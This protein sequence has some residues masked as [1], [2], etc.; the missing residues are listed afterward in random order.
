MF[1]TVLVMVLAMS[2][3]PLGDTAGKLMTGMG[4]AP[5]FVAWSRFAL[6][7]VML[8]PIGGRA[9]WSGAAYRDWRVWLRA[10]FIV[11]GI[12][13]ILTALQTEPI[14][15]VFGAF[16]VGP[17]LSYVL[18]VVLLGERVNLV[19]SALLAVGFV[20]VMLV[21]KPGFGMTPGMG[22]A[23]LAGAFYG[24]YLT[25]SRWLAG[26]VP[27]Q[28]LLMSQLLIGAVILTPFGIARIPELSLFVIGLIAL[29][30]AASMAGN[31]L[32]VW[33]YKRAEATVL[34]PLVYSQL[35]AA[36]ALGWLVFGDLPDALGWLGLAL[37][38]VSGFAALI[39]RP[40]PSN[41]RNAR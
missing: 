2:L 12:S 19:R 5:L 1:G 40:N 8:V 21:V 20:G 26:Q 30:A 9:A 37:L 3:I 16:F 34:A 7:A 38:V 18:S 11:G 32:L 27:A 31:M 23:M 13:S 35:L 4:I 17:I 22:F 29:S 28:A 33:A 36:T 24:S 15:N 10:G 41:R 39:L 6:G 25:A 14:A